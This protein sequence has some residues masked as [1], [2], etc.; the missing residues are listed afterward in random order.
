MFFKALLKKDKIF[1]NCASLNERAE[2]IF[3]LIYSYLYRTLI[4]RKLQFF[5]ISELISTDLR[6]TSRF[7][8]NLEPIIE[9][10]TCTMYTV[11]YL[12][13]GFVEKTFLVSSKYKG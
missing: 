12:T 10:S 7:L 3:L 6:R 13:T 9:L 11:Q 5:K 1:Y 4:L 8:K 2:L